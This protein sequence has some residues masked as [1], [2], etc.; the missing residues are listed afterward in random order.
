MK[1][2]AY[3]SYE[4]YRDAYA[5]LKPAVKKQRSTLQI[6]ALVISTFAVAMLVFIPPTRNIFGWT[7]A[8]YG[9]LA[10][11]L[12]IWSKAKYDRCL[13]QLFDRNKNYMNGQKMKIDEYGISGSGADDVFSYSYAWSAFQ[14]CIEMPDGYLFLPTPDTFVRIPSES[15][16]VEQRR[17][18]L[19]WSGSVPHSFAAMQ[20]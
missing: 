18:I 3:I 4:Q 12:Q 19:V 10:Y 16:T 17:E 15:L 13:R 8:A 5:A 2:T 7:L 9:P 11:G 1:V 14:L 6:A 20:N